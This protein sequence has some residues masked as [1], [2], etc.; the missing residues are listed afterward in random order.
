[1]EVPVDKFTLFQC[2]LE[3]RKYKD[4]KKG[5]SVLDFPQAEYPSKW[6]LAFLQQCLLK[7]GQS[8]LEPSF[9]AGAVPFPKPSQSDKAFFQ[10]LVIY[11]RLK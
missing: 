7:L 2:D 4:C 9:I 11:L 10:K 1:M 8:T 6:S 3:H 5:E